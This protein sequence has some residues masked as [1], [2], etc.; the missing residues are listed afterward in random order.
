MKLAR[1]ISSLNKSS[2][3]IF[4]FGR[5][6]A[7]SSYTSVCFRKALAFALNAFAG[8][9]SFCLVRTSL[10][11]FSIALTI[12]PP[13]LALEVDREVICLCQLALQVHEHGKDLTA[14][15]Q[16]PGLSFFFCR[17]SILK[18]LMCDSRLGKQAG[19]K[20]S[21][22]KT[23]KQYEILESTRL[24]DAPLLCPW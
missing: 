11:S 10:T 7:V 5:V 20:S 9:R 17:I 13:S 2:S 16:V 24:H 1:S 18:C 4:P 14:G 6:F 19:G 12:S 22:R 3:L 15:E 8:P 23:A 21:V